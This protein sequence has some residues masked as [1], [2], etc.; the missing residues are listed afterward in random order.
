V[1]ELKK[2]KEDLESQLDEKDKLTDDVRV[3]ENHLQKLNRVQSF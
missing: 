3:R 1:D 2:Q